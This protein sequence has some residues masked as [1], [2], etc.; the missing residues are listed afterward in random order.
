MICKQG[1][2]VEYSVFKEPLEADWTIISNKKG[3]SWNP[4]LS[5]AHDKSFYILCNIVDSTLSVQLKFHL[6]LS[7][8]QVSI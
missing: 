8:N 6:V 5:L 2:F 4:K 1:T 3:N 7:L